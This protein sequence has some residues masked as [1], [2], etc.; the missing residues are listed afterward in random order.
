MAKPTPEKIAEARIMYEHGV[1]VREVA[2]RTDIP[3]ATLRRKAKEKG[4]IFEHVNSIILQDMNLQEELLKEEQE[5]ITEYLPKQTKVKTPLT[6][7]VIEASEL[8]NYAVETQYRILAVLR[9]AACT[10]EKFILNNPDGTYVKS[11]NERGVVT[12]GLTSEVMNHL[13][14]ALNGATNII[15]DDR[16]LTQINLMNGAV[17]QNN[18]NKEDEIGATNQANAPIQFYLPENG[19]K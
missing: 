5:L 7:C 10:A 17:R 18:S 13:V 6:E 19:R 15:K 2:R 4:W 11:K 14:P 8:R 12:Y 1:P 16:M 3:E 9:K